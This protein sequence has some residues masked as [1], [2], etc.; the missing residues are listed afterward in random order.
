[1]YFGSW[2]RSFS[3]GIAA[4]SLFIGLL[5]YYA[6]WIFVT[7]AGSLKPCGCGLKWSKK[8]KESRMPVINNVT[9]FLD[10]HKVDYEGPRTTC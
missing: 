8:A 9:R 5:L 3:R 2:D 6:R 1:M 4:V 7:A 10:L